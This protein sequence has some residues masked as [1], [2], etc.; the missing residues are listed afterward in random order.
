MINTSMG[1]TLFL[2]LEDT[3]LIVLVFLW[4][5]SFPVGIALLIF[6]MVK[7]SQL[8]QRV[9]KLE[10]ELQT[11]DVS[12]GSNQGKKEGVAQQ[13]GSQFTNYSYPSESVSS[14]KTTTET[15]GHAPPSEKGPALFSPD[16]V[17][18]KQE[19]DSMEKEVAKS[20]L[21]EG[22]E[23]FIG[24]KLL[25]RIGAPLLYFWELLFF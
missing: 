23:F 25:N 16:P 21:K 2:Q 1:R 10:M 14:V 3:K 15:S 22:W 17:R 8:S 13:K 19:G 4:L 24:G 6:L 20:V 9:K 5:L 18:G 7:I 12:Y 11:R